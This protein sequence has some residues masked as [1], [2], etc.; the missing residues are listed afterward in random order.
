MFLAGVNDTLTVN[1]TAATIIAGAIN[2]NPAGPARSLT[3]TGTGTLTLTGTNTYTAQTNILGGTVNIQNSAALGG[4]NSQPS[5]NATTN[6]STVNAAGTLVGNGATLQLEG[7]VAVNESLLLNG[8][9]LESL[10]GTNIVAGTISLNLPSTIL[11]DVG[12]LTINGQLS[13]TA[14]LNKMGGGTLVLNDPNAYTGQTNVNAG[15]LTLGS[16]GANAGAN[17]LG[18]V[19]SSVVVAGGA[20]LQL[21]PGAGTTY[22]GKQVILSGP[23]LGHTLSSLLL[24]T[25]AF[26]NIASVASTWTGNIV[27][28]SSDATLSSTQNT[29]TLTGAISGSGSLTKVGA[30]TIALAAAETY[31]GATTVTAGTLAVNGVGQIQNTSGVTENISA[32]LT[33]DNTQNSGGSTSGITLSGRLMS[34]SS[35]AN[36]M[37]NNATFNF[38]GNNSPGALT[39]DAVGA[40]TVNSGASFINQTSG[41]GLNAAVTLTIAT[42]NRNVGATLGFVSGGVAGINTSINTANNQILITALGAGAALYN[43]SNGSILPWATI[44]TLGGVGPGGSNIV[45]QYDFVTLVGSSVAAFSN[46]KTTLAAAGPN[47][48]VKLTASETLVSNKTVGAIMA[49]GTTSG[50]NATI[51]ENN[52][53]LGVTS[54]AIMSMGNQTLTIAGGTVD[55]GSA[56]GILNE[57][58]ANITVTSSLTGTNGLTLTATTA[59]TITLSSANSYQGTTTV[60]GTGTGSVTVGNIS[61]FSNGAVTLTSGIFA[62]NIGVTGASQFSYF[63]LANPVNFTNSVVTFSNATAAS[64]SVANRIFFVGPITL[65]GN[66]QITA[67]A[68]NPAFEATVFSGV[69]SGTGSLNLIG[70]ALVMQNPNNTYSGGTNLGSGNLIVTASDTVS[71]GNV[72]NGPLG[73]GAVNLN[74]GIFQAAASNVP[75]LTVNAITLHNTI[76]LINANTIIA[77]G[78]A[79]NA[80]AGGNITFAGPVTLTGTNIL[81]VTANFNFTISGNISGTGNLTKTN[82][83]ALLLSGNN[84]FTGGVTVN[85]GAGVLSNVGDLIVGSNTALGTGVLTLSGG[86]LQDDGL[87]PRTLANNVFL[88]SNTNSFINAI[89][90]S[91]PFTFTGNITGPGSLTKGFA[92]LTTYESTMDAV[93][94]LTFGAGITGGTFTLTINGSTTQAIT[95]SSTTATLVSNIQSAINALNNSITANYLPMV[96]GSGATISIGFQNVSVGASIASVPTVAFNASGLSGGTI[97]SSTATTG[98]GTLVLASANTYTGTTTVN[99][100]TLDC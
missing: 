36:V 18:S 62:N 92:S 17:V 52:F 35:A 69:V 97:T 89:N 5:L 25:G 75:D 16:I 49:A 30:G 98:T 3:L 32:A 64:N 76:N 39:T 42:L 90:P 53:T 7:G 85:A 22:A 57:N 93:Q 33:L 44:G 24:P 86:A 80:G 14:D 4:N 9:T 59:G 94:T 26:E 87:A 2:D 46:Y 40:L 70:G 41:T 78:S 38:L 15:I 60:N 31:T 72:T 51:T 50:V 10:T 91:T 11:V 74:G 54:G 27:L 84:T 81:A 21:N 67:T 37:L 23:G 100:G 66:N 28:N 43:G 73:T 68:T 61:S 58:N 71:G 79:L 82:V 45:N 65:T 77:S 95:W 47:D 8:G 19:A 96:T 6:A 12:Q 63:A 55:F 99:Q 83:G 48:I 1:N 20:T 34:G 13:G 56:E 88:T 29:V